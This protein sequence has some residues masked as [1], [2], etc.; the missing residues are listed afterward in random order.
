MTNEDKTP[1]D[2]VNN[3][4]SD[5]AN[6][7]PVQTPTPTL[8]SEPQAPN[9][10]STE[11]RSLL[12]SRARSF[13]QSPQV[14]N[15]GVDFKRQFLREK[16]IH[17]PEINSLLQNAPPSAPLVPPRTY[18]QP[19]PSN[20]PNLLLGISRVFSWLAGSSALLIFIY[21]VSRHLYGN[22]ARMF[23]DI[24]QRFL[25]PRIAQ[26]HMARHSLKNHHLTLM[27]RFTTS[28][29]SF[30]E[31]QAETWSTLPRAHAWR[32]PIEFSNCS[33][34][35]EMT[36]VF[37]EKE[38][39]YDKVSPVTVLR[40]GLAD[41]IEG[42]DSEE[43]PTT[44]ELFRYLE[45]RIP[46]LLSDDG[47]KYEQRLWEVLSSCP[48]FIA[49]P[50]LSAPST[51]PESQPPRWSYLP[52]LAPDPS[53]LV[54]SLLSLKLSLPKS[55]ASKPS[56]F[57]KT[58]QA[59]SEFTGYISTQVYVPYR[60]P[61]GGAGIGTNLS[62]IEEQLRREIRALKGL[63]LNRRSFLTPDARASTLPAST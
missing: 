5:Q 32:E 9:L 7:T 23:I 3:V 20:L 63:V 24:A 53:P 37:G 4:P 46:W 6:D 59:L 34:I 33:S 54:K 31:S 43:K 39:Q 15:Q 14:A 19:P 27:R 55:Q 57:Q 25:L 18:P 2:Q 17:E 44:E 47:A 35:D 36:G 38:V 28:L 41:F 21:Y 56:I 26:S 1:K 10:P 11:D 60:P 40:C 48:L 12:L 52:P 49:E 30:K 51:S 16:G 42:Q 8:V 62:P 13:L 45:E 29:S 22:T 58:F 61:V 50:A